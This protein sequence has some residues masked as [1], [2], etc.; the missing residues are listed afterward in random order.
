MNL[1][2][3]IFA[4]SA[5]ATSLDEERSN[6]MLQRAFAVLVSTGLVLLLNLFVQIPQVIIAS[7][8]AAFFVYFA[9]G[10]NN[11]N[12]YAMVVFLGGIVTLIC[13]IGSLLSSY[14]LADVFFIFI[15]IFSLYSFSES[16]QYFRFFAMFANCLLAF[17]VYQPHTFTQSTEIVVAMLIGIVAALLTS[18]I[19]S[20]LPKEK[21]NNLLRKWKEE[22][23]LSL[24]QFSK[25]TDLKTF[26]AVTLHLLES[27]HIPLEKRLH[28]ETVY[29]Y[30]ERLNELE[31]SLHNKELIE[32]LMPS[33]Q[34]FVKSLEQVLAGK[35]AVYPFDAIEK[36][37]EEKFK[38]HYFQNLQANDRVAITRIQN[39]LKGIS[40]ELTECV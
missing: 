19:L 12:R 2:R 15:I 17:S 14:L 39:I 28:C 26:K 16:S 27:Q 25:K 29:L 22:A 11:P 13:F 24:E 38:R 33:Y 7:L 20:P 9:E 1:L 8:S 18:M 6:Y 21:T 40:R 31:C 34:V 10:K 30:C 4:N 32:T 5:V 37:I 36:H 3:Y 23:I 35:T